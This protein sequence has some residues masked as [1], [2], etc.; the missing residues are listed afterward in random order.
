MIKKEKD[1]PECS[2]CNKKGSEVFKLFQGTDDKCIC[3]ECVKRIK[4]EM[5]PK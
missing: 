1:E 4:E 2:F 3:N 5:K